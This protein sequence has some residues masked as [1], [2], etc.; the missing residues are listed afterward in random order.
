VK[1]DYIVEMKGVSK[2]FG[3]VQ[4]LKKVDL[5]LRRGE[6][7]GLVGDN[8]AGKSTLMK[9]LYGAVIPDEGEILIEAQRVIIRNPRDAQALGIAMCYQDLALF[10][11]LDVA[12]NVFSGREYTRRLLRLSFL[13]KKRMH[14]EAAELLDGLKINISSPKLLVEKMSGGQRQMVAAARAI[15]FQAQILIMDEPTA[16]LGVKE[17]NTLLKLIAELRNQ[18]ISIILITQRI[19]DVLAIGDRAMVLKAG[20]RQGVLEVD[21]CTLEDVVNLIIKGRADREI[22]YLSFG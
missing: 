12:L 3:S 4:A 10:H 17:A 1:N 9:V 22:D 14:D 19:P 8:A 15:G 18:G 20:E 11:N 6:V 5:E 21:K 2:R 13:N 16:A 7:L